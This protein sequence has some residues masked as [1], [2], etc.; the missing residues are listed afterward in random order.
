MSRLRDVASTPT[1][2]KSGQP[3]EECFAASGKEVSWLSTRVQKPKSMEHPMALCVC[4]LKSSNLA[5]SSWM[6][7]MHL[8]RF[9]PAHPGVDMGKDHTNDCKTLTAGHL[10]S[11]LV[12]TCTTWQCFFAFSLSVKRLISDVKVASEGHPFGRDK[13]TV[14]GVCRR[15]FKVLAQLQFAV[16]S[17]NCTLWKRIH[18]LVDHVSKP[19]NLRS[20]PTCHGPVFPICVV[21]CA[22]C[23]GSQPKMIFSF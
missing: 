1:N 9:Y 22:R 17:S 11:W 20:R 13:V 18:L 15:C 2:H 7:C 21:Q 23:G 8:G 4:L 14:S 5:G 10:G 19:L 6:L 12:S 16:S 3:T